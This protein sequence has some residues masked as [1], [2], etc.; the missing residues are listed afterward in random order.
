[1]WILL[2]GVAGATTWTVGSGK[3]FATLEDAVAGAVSGDELL[4]DPG[5]W[6]ESID[7]SGK[8]L[9]IR[10]V[11]G[12]GATTLA[13]VVGSPGFVYH[14]GEDG[15]LE[16]FTIEAVDARCVEV[17]GGAPTVVD[18]VMVGCGRSGLNGG[19]VLVSGGAPT[20]DDVSIDSAFGS[21]GGGLWVGASA[22]VTLIDVEIADAE[23]SWGGALYVDDATVVGDGLSI[24]GPIARFEGAGLVVEDGLV[25]V[26]GLEILDAEGDF[27]HGV[28]AYLENGGRLVVDGGEIA[29]GAAA[30]RHL[31]YDG[32]AIFLD[33]TSSVELRDVSLLDNVARA[34]G[35][36]HTEGGR[37]E[38]E[39]VDFEGNVASTRGGAIAAASSAEVSCSA[40]T[41]LDNEAADGGAVSLIGSSTLTDDDSSFTANVASDDGGAVHAD[42][43]GAVVLR[44]TTLLGNQADDSGGGL[45]AASVPDGITVSNSLF[46]G[47]VANDGDGG[48]LWIGTDT[49]LTVAASTLERNEAPEGKGGGISVLAVVSPR[50]LLL[51]QVRLEG[52]VA[53]RDGG[54]LFVQGEAVVQLIDGWVAGNQADAGAG[55]MVDGTQG[56]S[57]VRT[58]FHGNVAAEHGGGVYEVGSL[59][60]SSYRSCSLVENEASYGG[61]IALSSAAEADIVN[62]T[63]VG[64]DA[65]VHGAHVYV[66]DGTVHLVN[67]ITAF[68]ADGGGVWGD[69]VADAGSDRF[70]HLAWQNS[71]GNWVGSFGA[72]PAASGN[73]EDDPLLRVLTLD[74]DPTDDDLRLAIGSPAID[75]GDP[76]LFDVGG[77]RSDIGAWG[78]EQAPR[79]DG[80][81]DGTYAHADC[82]D[83]DP[84]TYPGAVEV[85]YDGVDQD[86]DGTDATDLDGDGYDGGPAGSDCD[87]TDAGVNPGVVEVY[88]DGVDADCSGDDDRDA[89]GDGFDFAGLKGGTDCDD[90]DGLV[91]PAAF[92]IWY[93]GVDQDCSGTSDHDQDGDGRD[94]PSGGGL[95]CDDQDADV[96]DGAVEVC[97]A[98]DDDCDGLVDDQ[99]IDAVA[100]WVDGDGDGYG[101]PEQWLVACFPSAGIAENGLDCDDTD[102][103]VNP[104][105]VEVWY[106]GIDDDCDGVDDDQD[107]D[108]FGIDDD[109]DDLRDTAFPG[110][111]EERNGL[112]DDCDGFAEDADRDSDGLVDWQEWE[113]GTQPDDPDTDADTVLDGM[114][115]DPQGNAPDSDGDGLLDPLDSD[116]DGDFVPT[117]IE[118]SVDV[119]GDGLADLDVDRN[120]VPNHL[121]H[122]TDGDGWPDAEEGTRDADA[123]GVPDF[124]DYQGAFAGGGC[125]RGVSPLVLFLLPLL[126]GR[127]AAAQEVEGLD[128]HNF[129]VGSVS[130]D[131]RSGLRLLE[132]GRLQRGWVAGVV[133]DHAARPL[134]ERLVGGDVPVVRSLTTLNLL[135]SGTPSSRLRF[136]AVVPVHA[137]GLG[138]QGAFAAPGDIKLA[139][140]GQLLAQGGLRPGVSAVLSTWIPTGASAR[141]VGSPTVAA[142]GGV[143]L[144]Q[145]LGSLGWTAN[146]GVRLGPARTVRRGVVGPG[147]F[148]GIGAH[149]ATSRSWGLLAEVVVDGTNG[150]GLVGGLPLE[151]ALGVRTQSAGGRWWTLSVGAGLSDAPGVPSWRVALGGG[152]SPKQ[153]VRT[154]Q[155]TSAAAA[156]E[157]TDAVV[158]SIVE[159]RVSRP[160]PL[161]ALVDDKIVVQEQVFFRE[162]SAAI[163]P[164]STAVLDAVVGIL[165]QHPEIEYLLIEG[166][167]NHRGT[168]RYNYWLSDARAEAVATWLVERGI[169]RGRLLTEG[170]GFD[171]PLL[172]PEDPNA[173]SVNRRVEFVVLRSDEDR[174]KM[175][176]PDQVQLD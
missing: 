150:L 126:V 46:D 111:V 135:F 32:G 99:A 21:R 57:A 173:D 93:D 120:G 36:I 159:V 65:D 174:S 85:P 90:T 3:D 96:F 130:G 106:D 11:D 171:R 7:L 127:R 100:F 139:A 162:G 27:T 24:T 94:A 35:A 168:S 1:M 71:G 147:W 105:A 115:V 84:D 91:N 123:D 102:P 12:S 131:P 62:D 68:G 166:H 60:S 64:N 16:G 146:A 73:L 6:I 13:P 175:R 157:P 152:W 29:R 20:F 107:A 74:G 54:G 41:F 22:L 163:H 128:A 149:L 8:D 44:G 52:N 110:A 30:S 61:G 133:L 154:I 138:P 78:G 83:T 18:V 132:A 148:G 116:D 136:D 169:S 145:R 170:V 26:V 89:D 167:T 125:S 75:A 31:G 88:Y 140:V 109:C 92:E 10:G 69:A 53:G 70:Y 51:Q 156:E 101:D 25:D 97:N 172:A 39:D 86:C 165:R 176:V 122:D 79:I 113:I 38:L 4:V 37:V 9:T 45:H 67:T 34:G 63:F 158:P 141:F 151:S 14:A 40:C 103:L 117:R 114:E 58:T 2:T 95:D 56:L 134:V 76:S 124:A 77:S 129:D 104:A 80:D 23:A 155:V 59:A 42:G 19:A 43:S 17:V 49:A 81:A 55:V 5:R 48:A 108:G 50:D 119:D 87:D 143:A 28:G 137:L 121:D 164:R 15:V 118:A 142:G 66:A 33:A 161:A 112:D 98:R 47:N 82:D 153:A 160:E 144:S 72:P